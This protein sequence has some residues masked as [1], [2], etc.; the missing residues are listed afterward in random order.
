VLRLGQPFFVE[1]GLRE[2]V[3]RLPPFGRSV[4]SGERPAALSTR[5]GESLLVEESQAGRR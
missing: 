3:Q 1:Q 4:F 2:P 5:V